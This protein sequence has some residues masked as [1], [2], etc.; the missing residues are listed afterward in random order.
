MS[1]VLLGISENSL[2]T[3]TTMIIQARFGAAQTGLG[4]QFYDAAGDLLGSRVTEGISALPE[5]GSYIAN[6]TVP[7]DAVGVFWDSSTSEA[8][9]DLREALASPDVPTAAE[10]ADEVEARADQIL[11]VELYTP[12]EAPAMVIP[13]PDSDESLTVVYA[14]TESI[15]NVKRAG[16]EITLKLITTPAKSE[17]VLEIAPKTMTTDAEGYAQM[18][19]QRGHRYRVTSRDLALNLIIQPTIETYNLLLD[20]P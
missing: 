1:T 13:A 8:T 3:N 12:A 10:I 7:A 5:A 18:T 2:T 19:V 16:I 14:Y 6:A 4:Y 15:P 9:E 17:R 20:I 11:L